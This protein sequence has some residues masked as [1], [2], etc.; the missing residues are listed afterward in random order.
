MSTP[1]QRKKKDKADAPKTSHNSTQHGNQEE[2]ISLTEQ[3]DRAQSAV[4]R[5]HQ[6]TLKLHQQWRTQLFRLSFLVMVVTLHIAQAPSGACIKEIKKWNELQPDSLAIPGSEAIILV[7]HD[8]TVELLSI[9]CV[10]CLLQCLRLPQGDFSSLPYRL[11]CA[12]L[13]VIISIYFQ[14]SSINSSSKKKERPTCVASS[15]YYDASLTTAD[16]RDEAVPRHFPV[17][18]VFHLIVSISLWFMLYQNQQHDKNIQLLQKLKQDLVQTKA[19]KTNST[20][21]TKQDTTK[22]TKR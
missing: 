8:A 4:E 18:L 9:F 19:N 3:L 21:T 5:S 11:S 20:P 10:G 17:A 15:K 22:K 6:G 16:L 13:P 2:K 1:Q 12:I 14:Q 7:L